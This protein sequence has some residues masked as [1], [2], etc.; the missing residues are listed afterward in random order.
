MIT[1]RAENLFGDQQTKVDL[2]VLGEFVFIYT[3]FDSE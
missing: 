2:V 1:C 3:I